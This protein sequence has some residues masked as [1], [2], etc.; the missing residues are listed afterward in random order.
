MIYG[1]ERLYNPNLFLDKEGNEIKDVILWEVLKV[2]QAQKIKLTFI[3]ANSKYRQ[4]IRLAVDV[5]KG[6]VEIDSK[7]YSEVYIFHDIGHNKPIYITCFAESGLLSIYNVVDLGDY[8]INSQSGFCG[9]LLR[10]LGNI[11][12]YYC[13]DMGQTTNFDKLIF[14]LEL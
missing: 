12:E 11:K 9:M 6:Y 5:G 2:K 1:Q 14:R 7:K 3:S 10:D 4:G 8:G 13:N